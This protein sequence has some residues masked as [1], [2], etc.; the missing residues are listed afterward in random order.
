MALYPDKTSSANS[1]KED[2]SVLI[3]YITVILYECDSKS[4]IQCH[5]L[6]IENEDLKELLDIA[7]YIS[8]IDSFYVD[9]NNDF[10][11]YFKN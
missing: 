10:I 3:Y 11:I 9:N 4:Q 1:S 6:K 5:D 8:T 2:E 7:F